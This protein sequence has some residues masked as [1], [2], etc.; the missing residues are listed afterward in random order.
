[1]LADHNAVHAHIP[2]H[3]RTMPA[4][5]QLV[6]DLLP[7]IGT[8]DG[9]TAFV[10]ELPFFRVARGFRKPSGIITGFRVKGTAK[11]GFR[12]AAGGRTSPLAAMEFVVGAT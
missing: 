7:L 4:G 5:L 6:V 10:N 9:R 2:H 12:A 8:L 11:L 1:M 3:R